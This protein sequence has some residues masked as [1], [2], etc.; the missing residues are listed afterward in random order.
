V[1]FTDWPGGFKYRQG[2]DSY[3]TTFSATENPIS[4]SGR[5]VGGA[6]LGVDWNDFQTSSNHAYGKQTQSVPPYRDSTG[7]YIPPSGLTSADM[8]VE[9]QIYIDET[10][11][12]SWSGFHELELLLRAQQ[13]AA[14]TKVY[15][16]LFSCISGTTYCQIM[17]WPGPVGT[18]LSDFKELKL[19]NAFGPMSNGDWIKATIIGNTINGYWRTNAGSYGAPVITANVVTDAGDAILYNKGYAGM[20]HWKNGTSNLFDYAFVSWRMAYL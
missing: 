20:G 13:S 16:V 8:E 3:S 6:T 14:S 7:L 19:N 17:R 12:A 18:Q 9:A 2:H 4:E 5:W 1:P 11:R 15:E 10:A